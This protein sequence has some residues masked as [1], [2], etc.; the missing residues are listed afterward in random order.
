LATTSPW[1]IRSPSQF[2]TTGPAAMTSDQYT[3]DYTE[4]KNM[5]DSIN[6]GRTADQTLFAQFWQAGNPPDY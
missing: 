4:V 5:G 3:A 6:S 2:R 1:V